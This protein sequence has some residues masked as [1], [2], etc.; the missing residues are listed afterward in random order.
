[1]NVVYDDGTIMFEY[2]NVVYAQ[3]SGSAVNVYLF[4][5]YEIKLTGAQVKQFLKEYDEFLVWKYEIEEG[6]KEPVDAL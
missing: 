5:G 6:K 2:E 4:A 3:K 1:M